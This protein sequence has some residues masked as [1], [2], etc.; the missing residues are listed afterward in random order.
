MLNHEKPFV[1]TRQCN[2]F[3]G[4][5]L[6][7]FLNEARRILLR[8][9]TGVPDCFVKQVPNGRDLPESGKLAHST[10][11]VVLPRCFDS[12]LKGLNVPERATH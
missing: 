3:Q 9:E 6:L 1:W 7:G 12:C 11:C 2:D 10:S 5:S 4:A 8:P